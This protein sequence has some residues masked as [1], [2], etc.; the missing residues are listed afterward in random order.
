MF[1]PRGED[2]RLNKGY[3]SLLSLPYFSGFI[4]YLK[5]MNVKT[6][7]PSQLQGWDMQMLGLKSQ[8]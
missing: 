6:T 5:M 4:F 2:S 8:T 3:H 7:R 1:D